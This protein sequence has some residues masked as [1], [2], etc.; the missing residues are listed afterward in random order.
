VIVRRI[1]GATRIL[2]APTDWVDDGASCAG[3][4]VRDV[5]T[6]VGPFMISAWEPTPEELRALNRGESLL[7]CVRGTG[8]P[9]VA[10]G[11][12]PTLGALLPLVE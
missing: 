3:L 11:V 10:L 5:Q 4:P 8:H 12:S 7:L 6:Q 2:G 1:E 9:V